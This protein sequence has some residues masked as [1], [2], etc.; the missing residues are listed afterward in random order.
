MA[1]VLKKERERLEA[2]GYRGEVNMKK[3][4]G[5]MNVQAKEC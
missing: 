1:S 2:Q 4:N 5:V 3:D